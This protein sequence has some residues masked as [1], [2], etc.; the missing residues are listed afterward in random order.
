MTWSVVVSALLLIAQAPAFAGCPLSV[1]GM[2][3]RLNFP[4]TGEQVNCVYPDRDYTLD[5]FGPSNNNAYCIKPVNGNLEPRNPV[6]FDT[7]AA[8][9]DATYGDRQGWNIYTLPSVPS[10]GIEGGLSPFGCSGQNYTLEH[11]FQYP[12][13]PTTSCYPP[14]DG[15]K[16]WFPLD[17][18]SGT[19]VRDIRGEITGTRV[20]P[21]IVNGRVGK[22]LDFDGFGDY[23]QMQETTPSFRLAIFD[24]DFTIDAWI[25]TTKS[26]GIIVAKRDGNFSGYLFM[27]H[28]GRLLLQ[29]GDY[30]E[31]NNQSFY[32]NYAAPISTRVDDGNWHFVAVSV[33]RNSTTGGKMYVDGNLV[34]TFNPT[35]FQY[36]SLRTDASVPFMIGKTS[37]G[38]LDAYAYFDGIIDEVEL[39]GRVVP[40]SELDGIWAAGHSGK[41]K[42]TPA[43]CGNN[44]CEINKGETCSTCA[45]DCGPCPVCGNG[46][47]EPS[48]LVGSGE[49]CQTC[50]LDCG[51]CLVLC[52]LDGRCELGE[53][54]DCPDCCVIGGSND[55]FSLP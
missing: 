15:L 20:G 10:S 1:N 48:I 23:V 39:F 47:C 17:E 18:T 52:D 21:S 31:F 22:A 53:G 12:K 6:G 29:M 16:A 4:A 33:D 51:P 42:Q 28:S 14:P 49:T 11:V 34:Y 41:C 7:S 36:K 30:D 26:N 19:T 27:V 24:R 55:C 32:R 25:K 46:L 38:T 43:V 44:T 50:P 54:P 13:C 3:T 37:Q 8:C 35:A 5:V 45:A 2:F 9:V 40:E